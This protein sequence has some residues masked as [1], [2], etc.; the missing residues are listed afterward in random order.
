[1]KVMFAAIGSEIVS[2]ESLSAVLKQ[3]GHECALAFDRGMFDDKQYF[4]ISFLAKIFDDTKNVVNDIVRYKPDLLA[5]SVMV[6]NYQWCLDIAKRVKKEIDV[7]VIMGGIHPTSVPDICI[8]EDCVDIIC[9]GEG[10]YPLL[11]LVE[12]LKN[13]KKDYA[14]ANLWFKKDGKVIKNLPRPLIKDLDTLPMIDKDL[15]KDVI[16]ISSYYLTVTNKGCLSACSYCSQN[17]YASWE[18]ANKLGLFYRERS[19]DN[20]IN[21]LKYMKNKFHFKRVDIK[22]NV[23][24]VSKSWT[25]EFAK[26]YKKEI[27]IPFRIMGHPKTIDN[28]VALALKEAGCWHVQ[29]GIESFNPIVRRDW[30]NRHETNDDILNAL[31]AMDN[32]RLNYSVDLMVGIPGET[33][34]DII[35]ALEIFSGRPSLIRASIFWLK[36][37]PGVDITSHAFSCNYIGSDDIKKINNGLQPNYLSTG[38]IEN[39]QIRERLLNFQLFFRILPIT[40][41]RLMLFF[42]RKGRYRYFK[43]FPQIMAIIFAD[44]LVSIIR[45]DHWAMYAIYSYLW[46]IKRRIKRSL[47]LSRDSHDG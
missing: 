38:S 23:L 27:G 4:T 33:D 31:Q 42:I 26:K 34:A 1:M 17:F 30:L 45:I 41:K 32:V 28:E 10:E 43:Y 8:S 36:Y 29:I 40:P 5:F 35:N 14:I 16:P 37:L 21:E 46:E 3:H 19:V 24:A 9:L 2:L 22:N 12:S 47:K 25:F 18:R 20:V 15:F 44:I 7:P 39:K 6:D 13:G 11:D